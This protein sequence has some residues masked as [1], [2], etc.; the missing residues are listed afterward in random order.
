M[1]ERVYDRIHEET[2]IDYKNGLAGI[3]AAIEL[4]VKEGFIEADTDAVLEDFDER[5]FSV[6]NIPHLSLEELESIVYYALWRISGSHS[7]KKILITDI[8]PPIVNAMEEWCKY[9]EITHQGIVSLKET[10]E[11]EITHL[12][13]NLQPVTPGW[14]RLISRNSPYVS[15]TGPS[16]LFLEIMSKPDI[17]TQENLD[18]GFRNGLAGIGMTLLSEIDD[19]VGYA[20]TA[21]LQSDIT[22]IK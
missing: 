14:Y 6:K 3:G 11:T 1:L 18:L 17:F 21:L 2:P 9:H 19:N 22:H 15:E 7:K 4:L 5:I 8:L 13:H 20:W 12:Q 16:P 10:V